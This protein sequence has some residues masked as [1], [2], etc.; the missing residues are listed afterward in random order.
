MRR[1]LFLGKDATH[2]SAR[3]RVL[4][5]LPDLRR[6]GIDGTWMAYPAGLL[7]KIQLRMVCR[8]F[9]VVMIQ[10]KLPSTLE[11]AL[12]RRWTKRLVYDFDDAVYYKTDSAD[13]FDSKVRAMKFRYLVKRVDAVIAG[14]TVLADYA[15]QFND[16]VHVVPTA[17][18]TRQVATKQY[19]APDP[20]TII[21][22]VGVPKNLRHLQLL[23]ATFQ[24]LAS[25]RRIQVRILSKY[26]I[27]MPGVDV[28]TIP[29]R[30]DTQ[31]KEIA[32][33]D[34]GVM[35]LP[36]NQCTR[37]KCGYKALQY[38]AAAVPAVVS[39][40]GSNRQIM[41]DGEEGFVAKTIEDFYRP[42]AMLIDDPALR[43]SMGMAGRKRVEQQ[44]AVPV[45][46]KQ[47]AGILLACADERGA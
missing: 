6:E 19:G 17:V 10:R 11:T 43:A 36:D 13:T 38:M 5:L 8:P 21:G 42:L 9:D 20:T 22:W 15:R 14:N 32:A 2:P 29:W 4:N 26:G 44:F 39:D 34:I 31:E 24:R 46:A 1:V 7:K 12:L 33:F 28:K 16:R 27:E 30:L 35:P 41:K 45:V 18:E 40:V 37:G 3:A 23:T 47:V 25:Q